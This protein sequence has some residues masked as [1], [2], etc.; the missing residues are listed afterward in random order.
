MPANMVTK[1]SCRPSA[2]GLPGKRSR[3]R[4]IAAIRNTAWPA[5]GSNTVRDLSAIS[6]NG[7]RRTMYSVSLEECCEFLRIA[8]L[9]HL[10]VC[11]RKHMLMH[12]RKRSAIKMTTASYATQ[13]V[14]PL[15]RQQPVQLGQSQSR[16]ARPLKLHREHHWCPSHRALRGRATASLPGDEIPVGIALDSPGPRDEARDRG[17]HT[18]REPR[19]VDHQAFCG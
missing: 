5:H 14:E 12:R 2:S 18:R 13:A 3:I 8:L 19:A 15:S 7:S 1:Y 11:A 10:R 16:S 6:S 17:L 4:D 9:G